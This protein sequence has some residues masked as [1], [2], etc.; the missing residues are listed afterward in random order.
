MGVAELENGKLIQ[1][2]Y[3][4]LVKK[5]SH[6]SNVNDVLNIKSECHVSWKIF[7]GEIK[8]DKGGKISGEINHRDKGNKQE[9]FKDLKVL[10]W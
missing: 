6:I 1:G 5:E 2:V 7:Y 9:E 8:I 4:C 10:K 3:P